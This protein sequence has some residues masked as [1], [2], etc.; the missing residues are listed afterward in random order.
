MKTVFENDM[1]VVKE[2]G[3]D[4]DFI[5]IIENKTDKD[6]SIDIGNE[7]EYYNIKIKAND[8]LGLLCNDIDIEIYNAILSG[9]FYIKECE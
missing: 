9:Y 6:I 4:Y 1:I 2:T 7:S 3:R 8:W 5:A